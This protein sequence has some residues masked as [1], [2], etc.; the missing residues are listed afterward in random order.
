M[1]AEEM[2]AI[3]DDMRKKWQEF[4]NYPNGVTIA[5]CIAGMEQFGKLD[6]AITASRELPTDWK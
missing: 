5:G 3:L 4:Q 2:Q 1:S 6:A